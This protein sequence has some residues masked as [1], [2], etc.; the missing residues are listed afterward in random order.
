MTRIVNFLAIEHAT[1]P[2]I[3]TVNEPAVII[4]KIDLACHTVDANRPSL[5]HTIGAYG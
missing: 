1:V 3:T 4:M 5:S 2:T